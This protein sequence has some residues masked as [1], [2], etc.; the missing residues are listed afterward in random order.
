MYLAV[1][2]QSLFGFVFLHQG[3]G[4]C[5]VAQHDCHQLLTSSSP[6]YTKIKARKHKGG[7]YH[8][9]HGEISIFI[10]FVYNNPSD[11]SHYVRFL[12]PF[13]F[14]FFKPLQYW[15]V[16]W[17]QRNSFKKETDSRRKLLIIR[18]RAVIITDVWVKGV[19]LP[20]EAHW[21]QSDYKKANY[22][23]SL[24]FSSILSML[25]AQSNLPW[26]RSW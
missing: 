2:G 16:K 17:Q 23:S 11:Y 3:N 6:V 20:A 25:T 14:F 1:W 26:P 19:V 7:F 24:R 9:D 13:F 5:V 22:L 12:F 4:Q 10:P 15:L 21:F 18:R 8:M